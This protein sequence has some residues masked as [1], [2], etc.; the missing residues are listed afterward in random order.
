VGQTAEDLRLQAERQ[1]AELSRDLE[2]IGDRVSPGRM[3]ERRQAAL[4]QKFANARD[5][6]M[7]TADTAKARMGSATS[8][9]GDS[10]S[11]VGSRIGEAPDAI[12]RQTE[13]NPLAAGLVAFGAGM[14][15]AT[16]LPTTRKE[17]QAGQ[18]IQPQLAQVAEEVKGEVRQV[19]EDLKP[20]AQQAVE[21]VKGSAQ[22]A[23]QS[24]K[25]DASM[26]AEQVKSEASTAA[27]NV[28]DESSTSPTSTQ[29]QYPPSSTSESSTESAPGWAGP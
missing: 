21:E 15:L 22:D 5:A 9:V 6:V 10:A 18:R 1:R 2:A 27:Q 8:Q 14:V 26:R 7:G 4:R 24:V 19:A 28:R 16:V 20:A 11:G 25:D 12:R 23:A 13:G 29:P 3:M 17:E